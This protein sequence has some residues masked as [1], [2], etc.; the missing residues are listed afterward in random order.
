VKLITLKFLIPTQVGV[1]M[2]K[3]QLTDRTVQIFALGISVKMPWCRVGA[4]G[5]GLG[6]IY[7]HQ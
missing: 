5:A 2:C 6:S 3:Y 1:W 4:K 7:S